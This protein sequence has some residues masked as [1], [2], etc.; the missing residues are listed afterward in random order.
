MEFY[1]ENELLKVNPYLRRLIKTIKEGVYLVLFVLS[2][3]VLILIPVKSLKGLSLFLL[4]FLGFTFLRRKNSR[5]DIRE[6]KE[7]RINLNDYLTKDCQN[8]VVDSLTKA[9]IMKVKDFTVYFLKELLK[10]KEIK[11]LYFRLEVN[12]SDF[13]KKLNLLSEKDSDYLPILISAF[14]LAKSL[15]YPNIN[16]FLLFNSIRLIATE[17]LNNL[18]DEFEL[19]KEIVLTGVIMEIYSQKLKSRIIPFSSKKNLSLFYHR[20]RKRRLLNPALTSRVT[21]LLDAYSVDLTYAVNY[22]QVK[23]LVGHKEELDKL[24][25]SLTQG[26]NVLLI[27]DEGTGKETI[28]FHLAWLINNE[29]APSE[30][31]DFRV[32]KFD[33]GLLYAQTK[34]NF[35]PILTKILDEIITS[36]Y[37][38]L[39]LPHIENIILETEVNIMQAL[40]EILISKSVPIIATIDHLGYSK[41]LTRYDLDKYFEKIE[42]KELSVEESIYLLTLQSLLWE[43]IERVTISPKAISNAVILSHKFIKSK[44]LPGSAEEV[45]KEGIDLVKRSKHRFL[46][47]E[48][49]QEIVAE[50]IKIPLTEL[51]EPEREKLLNLE[52]LLHQRIVN[53]EIAIREIARVLKVYRTGLAKKKGPI[54][55]FLFVGPTGVGKT[56]TA[57]ALA[58]IY[59]GSEK[60][61]VRLDMVEFQNP[62]DIEKLIGNKE[63]TLIGRLTEPIRQNPYSLILLDEF[64]KTHP[65]ILKI[66]LPIF[67]EGFIKDALDRDIDFSNTLIICT[68]NAY[69]EFIKESIQRGENFDKITNELKDKLTSIF[70]IE[71]LN[72]FDGIIVYKPLTENELLKIA[73]ILI[74]DFKAE[75]VLNKGIDLE[76]SLSALQELVRLGTDPIYG[77][78]PLARKINEIIRSEIA[79]LIL[80]EKVKRGNK[81]YVDFDAN[82][83][84]EII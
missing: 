35:L 24:I 76:I 75:L 25:K 65:T 16:L 41:S 69:S 55:V 14:N 68:S 43:E 83:K 8:F 82:F 63:G 52:T 38:I 61:M 27:G 18:F 77:A 21:S 67:D 17:T 34:D 29:L 74:N 78:R 51:K 47:S 5:E 23:F 19:K 30:L 20:V 11:N 10:S 56:E 12:I 13:S 1:F 46:S 54:G 39:Y 49:I 36:G 45:I 15:N 26:D 31:L 50:K 62:E 7:G 22:G 73:E 44:P 53:Q 57:K 9:E 80:A 64:E 28:V 72:R 32:V 60:T 33:L 58:K 59:Y 71:L 79:N 48:I 2:I 81:I 40:S 42:V 3:S 66:F 6:A 70:S 84:F 4:I 37:I